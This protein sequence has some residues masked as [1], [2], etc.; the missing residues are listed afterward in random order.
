MVPLQ[1]SLGAQEFVFGDQEDDV[2][3]P[4]DLRSEKLGNAEKDSYASV[5]VLVRGVCRPV[6]STEHQGLCAGGFWSPEDSIHIRPCE[7]S[8]LSEWVGQ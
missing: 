4:V 2:L 1:P 7:I 3:G 8:A 5:S 6:R